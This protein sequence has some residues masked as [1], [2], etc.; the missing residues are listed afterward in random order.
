MT[1]DLISPSSGPRTLNMC[2]V[3]LENLKA[4][5]LLDFTDPAFLVRRVLFI[6]ALVPFKDKNT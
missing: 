1:R 4:T 2:V 6:D 5:P 3:P